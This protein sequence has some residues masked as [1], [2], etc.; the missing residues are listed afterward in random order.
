MS[1]NISSSKKGMSSH[2]LHRMLG[3]TYKTAWFM[4]HRIREGMKDPIFN[5]KMGG[6]GKVVEVDETFWGNKGKHRKVARGWAHKE[7]IFSLVERGGQVRSFHVEKVNASTLK[8]IMREQIEK[9]SCLVTDDFKSYKGLG[10]E[11]STHDVICHSKGEY[12]RD[13]IHTNTIEGFFSIL[14]RGL[15]G[16]Y[17]HVSAQHLKRYIGEFDFRYK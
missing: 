1:I 11:F 2:Q 5:Q 7:K 10:K 14:K 17:Q 6:K 8:R 4:T 12:V 3:V 9:D 16:V 13:K 15:T